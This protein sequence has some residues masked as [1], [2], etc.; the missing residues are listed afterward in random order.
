[1]VWGERPDGLQF[2]MDDF[3]SLL[4]VMFALSKCLF[5][6][7]YIYILFVFK[8]FCGTE[9][10]LKNLIRIRITILKAFE[11]IRLYPIANYS[12]A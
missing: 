12:S 3:E 2:G 9:I 1:M 4:I 8:W 10:F 6:Y 5:I 11:T 7:M